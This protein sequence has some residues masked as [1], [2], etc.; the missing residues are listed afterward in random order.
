M[1]V[2]R[3][4]EEGVRINEQKHTRPP[5]CSTHIEF[6]FRSVTSCPAMVGRMVLG[7][8][9]RRPGP[10]CNFFFG[11]EGISA[12]PISSPG[13]TR[14]PFVAAIMSATNSCR[15]NVKGWIRCLTREKSSLSLSRGARGKATG[16]S[17]D[18][19]GWL[20]W[21]FYPD[22]PSTFYSDNPHQPLPRTYTRNL[23]PQAPVVLLLLFL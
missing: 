15:L 18:S 22:G 20:V 7:G 14:G 13:R 19:F 12:E 6:L 23:Q 16:I 11:C 4:T 21:K 2:S 3:G 17:Q 9:C 5:F 1:C 10:N 8:M